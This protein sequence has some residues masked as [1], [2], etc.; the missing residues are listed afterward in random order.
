ML[1]VTRKLN[2]PEHEVNFC[3]S[4]FGNDCSFRGVQDAEEVGRHNA[5]AHLPKQDVIKEAMK[6]NA[7]TNQQSAAENLTKTGKPPSCA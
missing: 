5:I 2:V 3:L 6:L 1:F 7:D 4:V